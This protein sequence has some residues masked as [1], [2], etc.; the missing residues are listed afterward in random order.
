[1]KQ[2]SHRDAI[3]SVVAIVKSTVLHVW[4][5]LREWTL[6]SHCEKKNSVTVCGDGD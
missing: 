3:Y 6:S 1:M 4:K 2:I 5:L